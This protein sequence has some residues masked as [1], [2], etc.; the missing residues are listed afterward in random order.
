MKRKIAIVMPVYY[1]GGTL[2]SAKNIAITLKKESSINGQDLDIVFAY[3]KGVYD[4]HLDF[5]DLIDEHIQLREIA[6]DVISAQE[7]KNSEPLHQYFSLHGIDIKSPYYLIIKDNLINFRDVD[8]SVV[9]SDRMTAPLLPLNRYVM[10]VFDY[11]QRYVPQ[12]FDRTVFHGLCYQYFISARNADHVFVTTS[13]TLNDALAFAGIPRSRLSIYKDLTFFHIPNE[14]KLAGR[15]PTMN[16]NC[17]YFL[18]A[19]NI[20]FHKNISKALKS[21]LRYWDELDGKL[22][23][24]ITGADTDYLDPRKIRNN[25]ED[26]LLHIPHILEFRKAMQNNDNRKRIYIMGEVSELRYFGLLSN[27]EFVWNPT[28]Y[29]NGAFSL[30]EGALLGI[31][32]LSAYYPASEFWNNEMGLGLVFFDPHDINEMAKA[33][34]SM[35]ENI[36]TAKEKLNV[37]A[38]REIIAQK[39][40]NSRRDF[41]SKILSLL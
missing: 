3:P 10:I 12:V 24:V 39:S 18:W 2:R 17:R 19:T 5:Y 16:M 35:E 38:I 6:F 37:S 27:S 31:P 30:V 26:P 34:K 15:D 40:Q 13:A 21:L 11:L 8:L 20:N 22:S 33:L 36:L 23:L 28:L 25:K 9:I 7:I 29:D 32:S 4:P 1:R 41:Y 14:E